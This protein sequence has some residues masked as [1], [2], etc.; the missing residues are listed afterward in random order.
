MKTIRV[1]DLLNKI[2]NGEKVPKEI[3]VWGHNFLR[4]EDKI[5]GIYYYATDDE[6]DELM[7]QLNSTNELND[8]VEIIE[9]AEVAENKEI[10]K[11]GI[12][13]TGIN[14][15]IYGNFAMKINELIDAVNKLNKED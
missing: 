4:Y 11:M 3:K 12:L 14:S 8:E 15:E 6:K 10:K 5:S 13:Y 9:D 1:I 2:A 7:E